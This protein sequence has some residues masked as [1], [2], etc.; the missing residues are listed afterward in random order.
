MNLYTYIHC[1]TIITSIS[2]SLSC[3]SCIC[4]RAQIINIFVI[5]ASFFLFFVFCSSHTDFMNICIWSGERIVHFNL[6]WGV[7]ILTLIYYMS[8]EKLTSLLNAFHMNTFVSILN[9]FLYMFPF[10]LLK[11]FIIMFM[12]HPLHFVGSWI[13]IASIFE[14]RNNKLFVILESIDRRGVKSQFPFSHS[15][16]IKLYCS[17]ESHWLSFVE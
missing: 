1:W 8:C 2:S 3:C 17:D 6:K 16:L 15:Y 14:C 7:Y 9:T 4:E 12:F 11:Y 10:I 5:F 13:A